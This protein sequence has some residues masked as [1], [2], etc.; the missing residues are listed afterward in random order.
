MSV[1]SLSSQSTHKQRHH[2]GFDAEKDAKKIHSACKGAGKNDSVDFWIVYKGQIN[3]IK[4][5]YMNLGKPTVP[6]SFR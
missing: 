6:S 3:V 5:I 2:Q 4:S 1:V